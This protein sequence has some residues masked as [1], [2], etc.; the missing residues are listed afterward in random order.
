MKQRGQILDYLFKPNFG[1]NLQILKVEIGK[2]CNFYV[3]LHLLN[4]I[5]DY[6]RIHTTPHAQLGGDSQSTDGV[7]SSHMHTCDDENYDRG[8][9]WWLMK[10]A[11]QVG[12]YQVK[13]ILL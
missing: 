10:K 13:I 8:Y 5:Y 3:H 7:E 6:S 2:L 4:V 11:K 9:E 12:D 1:A